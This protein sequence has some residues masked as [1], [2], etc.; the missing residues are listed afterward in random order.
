MSSV[1]IQNNE[2]KIAIF[3]DIMLDYNLQ[4]YSNKIA[5]E[6]PIPVVNITNEEYNIGGCGNVVKN[7]IALGTKEVFLFS[8]IGEDKN[9]KIITDL[10]PSRII[11]CMIT[12]SL[13]K[14]ISKNRIY[15]DKKLI[16]R[17]DNESITLVSQQQEKI[18]IDR[19]KTILSTTKLTSIILSDYN[20]G[21]LTNYI[22]QN[23]ISLANLYE[24]PVIVDP[25]VD[26]NKF[27][28]CTVIKPNKNETNNIFKLN[29]DLIDKDKCHGQI[30]ELV[31]CKL[32]VI[33]LSSDGISAFTNNKHYHIS[34]NKKE[35]IDVTGAGDIVCAV[36]G[37]YYPFITDTFL[38][39]KIA[40]HL[41]SI[42]IGHLGVYTIKD[43]D[44]IE[45]YK[46][47][48]KS[49]EINVDILMKLKLQN[50]V[51][52]NGCFDI[53]HSAHIELFKFCKSKGDLVIV[54]L[55]SDDSIK[56]LKGVKRPINSLKER[57]AM[58][59]AIDYVDFIV[60]FDQ[61]TPLELIKQIQ[62]DYLIK[63]GDYKIENIVG[64]DYAKKTI[65]FNYIN[66]LSTTNI[67]NRIIH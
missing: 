49:K 46:Y 29:M 48:H 43:A 7:V 44:L 55:N 42:S 19:F 47:I 35:V 36:L 17:Y 14:T 38:L 53:L 64:R 66:G 63:G 22:C 56:R 9:G 67:V 39:I 34:E 21:F 51:F 62:P 16:A 8:R 58:L 61:D 40:N 13:F 28:G 45:T 4:G 20:K 60:V 25:K 57:I 1:Y 5:N 26:Y 27:V 65:I 23:V 15:A 59:N 18:I 41:A 10:L 6:A 24:I 54:G 3:G 12:D 2:P 50:T 11:N 37:T 30:Q 52:T 31:K 33:T 32:S